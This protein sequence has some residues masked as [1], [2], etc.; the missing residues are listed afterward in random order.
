V[1]GLENVC[2]NPWFWAFIAALGSMLGFLIIGS[3]RLDNPVTGSISFI[4]AQVP[5]A[6]LPLPFVE[7]PRMSNRRPTASFL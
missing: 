3:R 1:S 5:R 6:I 4:L 7:Q 2:T